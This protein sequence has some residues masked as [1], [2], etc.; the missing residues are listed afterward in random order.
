MPTYV[1][2]SWEDMIAEY[3]TRYKMIHQDLTE[4]IITLVNA[5]GTIIQSGDVWDAATMDNLEA[6]IAAAFATCF[7]T[8]TGTT[9]P[10]SSEGKNGDIYIKTETSGQT[11]TIVAEYVKISGEWIAVPTS[12][13]GGGGATVYVGTTA[14][15][16]S[17]GENGNLYAQYHLDTNNMPVIDAFFVKI[18]GTWASISTGGGTLHLE[19]T[20]AQY[21]AL[22]PAQKNNG[23]VY[24]ITDA[25]GD[26]SKFQPVIYSFDEREI[27]VWTDGKPL[28]EKTIYVPTVSLSSDTKQVIET[29]FVGNN[30]IS[31]TGYNIST[32]G[33]IYSI[34][35]GRFRV[36]IESDDLKITAINGG[37]WNGSAY[38][39]VTYTKSTDV[40]GSGTWTPQ[41]VPAAHYSTT[42]QIVGTWVD[43]STLYE[44][45]LFFNNKKAASDNTSELLHGVSNIGS[46][47]FVDRVFIDFNGGQDWRPAENNIAVSTSNYP[48]SWVV[49][50]SAILLKSS[51]AQLSFDANANRSYLFV[52]RYTKSST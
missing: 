23:T 17:V 46:V 47:K 39:T 37:S 7:E 27:G 5:F 9:T 8:L 52:I 25:N 31:Y 45:T 51:D 22:T 21:D 44:K 30:I 42:E 41:G 24:F 29:S 48:I 50:S 40:A 38:I 3:P 16:A 15:D 32:G 33:P 10:T 19:L 28:Y 11:T 49:G 14:P 43:G 4:E 12:G 34:P 18:S 35:D 13:G 1:S 2:K 36:F 26:G 6:R 20:Q